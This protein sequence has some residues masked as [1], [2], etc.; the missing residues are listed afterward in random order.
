MEIKKETNYLIFAW[1]DEQ[2]VDDNWTYHGKN[3]RIV[4]NM[5]LNFKPKDESLDNQ[6]IESQTAEKLEYTLK[7]VSFFP[8]IFR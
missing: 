5:L 3:R 1:N 8:T 2:I 7:N 6:I 4:V